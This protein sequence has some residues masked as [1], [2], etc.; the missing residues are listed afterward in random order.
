MRT[1]L[2]SIEDHGLTKEE[3]EGIKEYCMSG[4]FQDHGLLLQSAMEANS[5]ICAELYISL[6]LGASFE[7]IDGLRYIPISKSDFYAYRRKTV[8]IFKAYMVQVGIWKGKYDMNRKLEAGKRNGKNPK[9]TQMK[10]QEG[11]DREKICW[12]EK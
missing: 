9:W 11:N 7:R 12:S 2:M 5:T 1:R 10:I 4:N 3:Y 8:A 6:V